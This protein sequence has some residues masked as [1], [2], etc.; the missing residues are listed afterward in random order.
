MFEQIDSWYEPDQIPYTPEDNGYTHERD[1]P[2]LE[3]LKD[4]LQGVIEAFYQTG[5]TQAIEN[6]LDEMC[7]ALEMPLKAAAMPAVEK[8]GE[9]NMM[10][11]YL[12]YQ[13]SQI[14]LMNKNDLTPEDYK[15]Y[16]KEMHHG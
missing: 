2:D 4:H 5:D 9:R 12:G 3:H 13:R 1:M 8:R 16:T 14:D 6:G 10:Q 11:W 15:S 7:H